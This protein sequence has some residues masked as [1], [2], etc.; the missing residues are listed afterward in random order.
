MALTIHKNNFNLLRLLFASLVVY[1]H[2]YALLG[3]EEPTLWGRSLGN[4]SV[5]GFFVISGYLICQSYVRSPTIILFGI[6]RLLRIG[7]GLVIALIITKFVAD[8]CGGFKINPVPYIANGPVWTLTWEV[9]CYFGL[10]VLGLLGALKSTSIPGFFAATWLV[11]LAN[12]SSVG[13]SYIVIAPLAMMFLFGSFIAVM[14]G[15]IDFKKFPLIG[16]FGLAIITNHDVFQHIYGWTVSHIPFLWGPTITAEQVSRVIYMVT[17][18]LVLIYFGKHAKP[19]VNIENDVSYG[20]YIYGWPIAQTLVYFS[21]HQQI[22]LSS[23]LYFALTM[24]LTLPIAFVSWKFIEKPSLSLKR[25]F[26][27]D[28]RAKSA[29]P[30]EAVR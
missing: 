21:I 13:D 29:I 20:I 27:R 28:R 15:R 11:Y 17:F 5:H 7:P 23:T 30:Q 26:N 19:I 4:L 10:A 3:Q 25:L 2:A 14:E 1:S 24:A 16:I 22:T 9:I 8:L 12:I 18:P 6:N